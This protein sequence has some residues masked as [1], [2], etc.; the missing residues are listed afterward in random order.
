MVAI[1]TDYGLALIAE[2][3]TSLIQVVTG[4]LTVCSIVGNPTDEAECP[5]GILPPY[6]TADAMEVS[7]NS[8]LT[9][10]SPTSE[11]AST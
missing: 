9:A 8:N 4:I 6:T 5:N 10:E 2:R 1:R 7:I 3:P 11:L